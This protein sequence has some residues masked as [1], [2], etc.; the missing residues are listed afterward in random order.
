MSKQTVIDKI[1]EIDGAINEIDG[2]IKTNT[3]S[4]NELGEGVADNASAINTLK[5]NYVEET[6]S[7]VTPKKWDWAENNL[8]VVFFFYFPLTFYNN[9]VTIIGSKEE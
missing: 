8:I 5:W 3:S 4:I 7:G 2:A 9:Y 6:M 1:N